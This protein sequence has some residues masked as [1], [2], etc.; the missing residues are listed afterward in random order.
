MVFRPQTCF[1]TPQR[2][3]SHVLVLDLAGSFPLWPV[4]LLG[5]ASRELV[6]PSSSQRLAVTVGMR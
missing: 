5:N 6:C 1:L 3:V 4:D 2:Y